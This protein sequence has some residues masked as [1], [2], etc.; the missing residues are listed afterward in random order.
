MSCGC[1][2]TYRK[3]TKCVQEKIE[4]TVIKKI[5]SGEIYKVSVSVYLVSVDQITE[6]PTVNLAK[7][8]L[9]YVIFVIY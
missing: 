3:A 7:L 2:L 9:V 6:P 8:L 1:I 5:A 4:C